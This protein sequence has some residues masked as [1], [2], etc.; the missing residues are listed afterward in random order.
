MFGEDGWCRSCGVP[1]D[2][3]SGNL[4]LR[5][6]GFKRI[7]G[8]WMPNWQFDVLCLER[9]LAERIADKFR[10]ELRDV[11]WRGSAPGEAKQ[12]VAPTVGEAW[13]DHEELR[14]KLLRLH[15]TS[16]AS[17]ADCR[18]WR[19]M[20]LSFGRLPPLTDKGSASATRRAGPGGRGRSGQPRRFGVGWNAFRQIVVRRELP[21]SSWM[22]A[23]RLPHPRGRLSTARLA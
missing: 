20:P 9:E 11:D 15:G 4:V 1:R 23:P 10:V 21:R 8:A 17:C 2:A 14:E 12:I 7:D 16:G 3:Q 19:W 13:F 6:E 5:R 22:P 18:I